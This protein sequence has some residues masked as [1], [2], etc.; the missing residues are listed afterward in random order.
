MDSPLVILGKFSFQS[1]RVADTGD[2]ER[3]LSDLHCGILPAS[4]F[5]DARF[6]EFVCSGFVA[7]FW[8][9]FWHKKS[10]VFKAS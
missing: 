4:R 5:Q 8:L 9:A 3:T 7:L 2:V 10:L 6:G 1:V